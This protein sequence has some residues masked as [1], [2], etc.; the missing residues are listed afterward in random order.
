MRSYCLKKAGVMAI[1]REIALTL[2][3]VRLAQTI[4]IEPD[5]WQARVLRSNA[6]RLLLNC[7]R[8]VGK[9]TVTGLLATWTALFQPASL[10]L[11]LSPSLRQS[12]ELFRSCLHMYKALGRPVPA[13]AESALRLELRNGSRIVS[14][15]GSS[16]TVR[17][18]AGVR[19][20]IIDEASQVEDELY[21]S[22]RP[23][24]AV[25]NGRLVTLSTPYGTRGWWYQSWLRRAEWEYYEVPATACSRIS[26]AF[27]QEEEAA[28]GSWYFSQEYLCQFLDA[29]DSVFRDED[30]M[31]EHN[32]VEVW[33]L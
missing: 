5:E 17:G 12:S 4:G 21:L 27:L 2:D 10:I 9:S 19:L 15:P 28:M 6:P 29:A 1:G 8:Q 22:V 14:L 16:G 18:L 3:P 33:Q 32:E 11:L 26:K 25:S 31:R 23:M 13:E 24:L 30:I 7:S 20:L